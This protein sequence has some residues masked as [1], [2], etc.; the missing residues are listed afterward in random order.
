MAIQ[1]ILLID[2][3]SCSSTEFISSKKVPTVEK[4]PLRLVLPYSG[5][6][7]L[8]TRSKLQ[9]TFKEVLNCYKLQVIFNS[10]IKLCNNFWFK[11]PVPQFLTSGV[12]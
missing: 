7:S 10:Q 11:D 4:K 6:M 9:K 8:Q 5:T 12:I 1:N 2:V 3:L